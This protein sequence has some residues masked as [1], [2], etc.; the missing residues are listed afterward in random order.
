MNLLRCPGQD[1]RFWKPEDIFEIPCSHCGNAI[2]FFKDDPTRT[3]RNCGMKVRNPKVDLGCAR[4]CHYAAK[5]VGP[6]QQET[7]AAAHLCDRLIVSMK[8]V[9]GDDQRRIDHAL[10]VLEYADA[11]MES[12]R[13]VSA[14]VVRA[15]AVLHDIGTHEAER[16]HGSTAAKHQELEGPPI[17]RKILEDQHVNSE[18]IEHVCRIIANHHCGEDIE[19]PES[20]VV[21]DADWLV[22]IPDEFDLKDRPR[23]EGL[24]E[25][26]F[27]T[28]T[29]RRIAKAVLAS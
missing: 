10:K 15:A 29:G 24:V 11:I 9:F 22:I 1:M 19:T 13:N 17:A 4:W 6:Q 23:I 27:K 8:A 3:C 21:W 25:R 28:D 26:V 5:C 12:E 2:E 7:D 20:C 16:K 14:V 18:E